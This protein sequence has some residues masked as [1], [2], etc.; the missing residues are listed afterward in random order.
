LTAGRLHPH[1]ETF[2]DTATTNLLYITGNITQAEA[3]SR[4]WSDGIDYGIGLGTGKLVHELGF[5]THYARA[6]PFG[7]AW[8][9]GPS[10][11]YRRGA[12][13]AETIFDYAA[14]QVRAQFR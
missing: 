4:N 5:K 7:E 3:K 6:N 1:I 2:S 8:F 11:M 9:S 10:E 14:N 13:L 12:W